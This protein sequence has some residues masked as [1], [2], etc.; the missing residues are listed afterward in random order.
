[1]YSMTEVALT[2]PALVALFADLSQ[3]LAKT[4]GEET[5]K[6][7]FQGSGLLVALVAWH[8]GKAV[9]CGLLRREDAARAE[10]KRLYSSTP[11]VGSALLQALELQAKNQGFTS[12]LAASRIMNAKALNFFLH[13]GFKKCASYGK[14]RYSSQTICLE[15]PL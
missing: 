3:A 11:G 6:Q 10:I 13:K 7:D 1:M 5:Q 2:D 8:D 9:G 4:Q 15:K 12:V 14:Y